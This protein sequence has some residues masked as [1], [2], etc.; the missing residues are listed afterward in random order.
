MKETSATIEQ[1]TDI[2]SVSEN[3]IETT[4]QSLTT[5]WKTGDGKRRCHLAN[6][7]VR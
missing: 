4:G 5:L 7:E 3:E 6:R 1:L 2:S